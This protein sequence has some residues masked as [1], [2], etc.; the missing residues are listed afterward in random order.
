MTLG[1]DESLPIV[2]QN[3]P[4]GWCSFFGNDQV[5]LR[6]NTMTLGSRVWLMT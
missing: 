4:V 6:R 5:T 3:S 1:S 2:T